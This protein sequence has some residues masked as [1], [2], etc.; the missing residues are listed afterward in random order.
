MKSSAIGNATQDWALA[1]LGGFIVAFGYIL[2]APLGEQFWSSD[3]PRHAMNGAFVHD[4][5]AAMP[6]QDPKGFALQYYAQYPALTIVFYPPLFYLAEAVAYS[7]GGVSD[8][9]ALATEAMFAFLLAVGG[10]GI[11]RLVFAPFAAFGLALLIGGSPATIY[12]GRQVMLDIPYTAIIALA[13]WAFI[14]HL[15][16]ARPALLYA[17]AAAILAAFY[18]KYNAAFMLPA[19]AVVLFA[20]RGRAALRDR[21]VWIACAMAAVLLVPGLFMATQFALVNT[22]GIKG[23]DIDL[24]RWSLEAWVY[25]LSLLPSQIGWVTALLALPGVCLALLRPRGQAERIT[26]MVLFAWFVAG[27]LIFS[28]IGHKEP[29][30]EVVLLPPVAFFAAFA[31]HRLLPLRFGSVGIA[32]LGAATLS[33]SLFVWPTPGISGFPAIATYVAANAP[34]DGVVVF[35][36]YRDGNFVFAM[37]THGERRD[38]HTIRADKL[39]VNVTVMRELGTTENNLSEQAIADLLA[40]LGADMVVAQIGFWDDLVVMRRFEAVLASAAYIRVGSFDIA[41]D[42]RSQDGKMIAIYRPTGPVVH[43]PRQTVDGITAMGQ[44]IGR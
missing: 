35:S 32:A 4:L 9:S 43:P 27:Y 40:A 34:Q 28:L 16:S 21:H 8:V 3:A 18:I 41:G 15:Q 42:V 1:L 26:G 11:G 20:V 31:L 39:L 30:I 10:Y 37:R 25:Y 36:G 29:R 24:P 5:L 19:F 6:W 7:I 33:A 23:R 2:T 17:T 44:R 14:G 12:W 22:D 38:L 13:V